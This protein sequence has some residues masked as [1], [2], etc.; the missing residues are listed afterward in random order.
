MQGCVAMQILAET[1]DIASTLL[2][3]NHAHE[4]IFFIME[5]LKS[6]TGI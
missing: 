1:G 2:V 3:E 5:R 6:Y 4:R